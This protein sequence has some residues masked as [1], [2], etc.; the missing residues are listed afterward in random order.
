MNL[1]CCSRDYRKEV[2]SI[3][4]KIKLHIKIGYLSIKL[5]FFSEDD[6]RCV[7]AELHQ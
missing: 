7:E 3:I 5:F 2:Q 4:N 1:I 6:N